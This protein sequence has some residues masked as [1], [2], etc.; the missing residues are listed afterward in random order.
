VAGSPAEA[1][2]AG[3]ARLLRP[4]CWLYAEFPRSPRRSL[5]DLPSPRRRIRQRRLRDLG[6]ADVTVHGHWPTIASATEIVPLQDPAALALSLSRHLGPTVRPLQG[7]AAWVLART[8]A[9][10]RL[11]PEITVVARRV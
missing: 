4:G 7:P 8:G 6:F 5:S 10:A 9:L 11:A 1:D 2:L 3:G